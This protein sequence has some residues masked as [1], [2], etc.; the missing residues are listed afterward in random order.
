MTKITLSGRIDVPPADLAAVL[1]ELP[2]HVALTRQEPGCLVFRVEPRFDAPNV[3]DVYEEFEDEAAFEAHQARVRTSTW[4]TV[5]AGASRQY[6]IE[7][8]STSR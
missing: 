6:K 4:G 2:N 1:A 7:G 3:F 8:L 5:S